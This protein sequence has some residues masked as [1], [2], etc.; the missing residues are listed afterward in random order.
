LLSKLQARGEAVRCLARNPEHL[1]GRLEGA[2]EAVRGDLLDAASLRDALGGIE[3]AYYL[4]HSMASTGS[5]E[6]NDRKAAAN[7]SEAARDA[8]VRR[9]I[10]LGGLGEGAD[11]SPHLSSRHEVG[12]VLRSAG[13]Q[14]IELRASI[15]I[16]SG[17]LS[18]EMIRALVDRLPVMVTPRWVHVQAQPIAIED[19]LAY[20][21]EA[22]DRPFK[23]NQ[24]FEIGGPRPAT[25]G[26][27]M[28]EYAHQRGLRRLMIP[29]PVLTPH[30]SSLW[31]GL[32]TPV[33]ARVGRKLIDSMRNETIVRD[34]RALREFDVRP[35][36]LQQAVE[37]ALRNEDLEMA[38]TRWSDALSSKGNEPTYGG[39]RF[40]TR[41][42]DS[43]T[44][45]V[46]SPPETAF[47]EVEGI[48]GS[49]GWYGN[50]PLWRARG[51]LDLLVGGP[52][53]RRG[54]R[55]SR[56]LRR[57]DALDFWRVEQVTR[58]AEGSAGVLRLRAEMRL[59]GRA[60]L[61]FD[62]E[63]SGAGQTTIRQ[64]AI[65]A[66]AGLSGL[67]Y[68]YG[69]YPVHSLVFSRMIRAL[70]RAAEVRNKS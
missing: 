4:V 56:F 29:V 58:P 9:I 3:T 13:V 30:L 65:F 26:E 12:E 5:F 11:L 21:I 31:L 64:T 35:R 34:D 10:Y 17:S 50:E 44:I 69:L 66:P 57:G 70:G 22:K 52:G 15:V 32:I 47:E 63:P 54:R 42:V 33:Y 51:F 39:E 59:P 67:A 18:F 41:L 6:D 53:M 14:V 2:S 61:Q 19:V 16:G 28:M 8:G 1:E 45:Q 20:L 55:D 27:M 68:W 25:Y 23:G 24:I 38:E 48:G 40:G 36:D 37:R 43:R 7:F 46:Q 60:W 49:T 62:V